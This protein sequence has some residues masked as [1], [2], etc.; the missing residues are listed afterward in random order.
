MSA[1]GEADRARDPR[2]ET[3]E[4]E[5]ARLAATLRSLE[6]QRDLQARDLERVRGEAERQADVI[7][8]QDEQIRYLNEFFLAEIRRVGGIYEGTLSWRITRPLRTARRA[9]FLATKL[10]WTVA[11]MRRAQ[12]L[13]PL[14]QKGLGIM[15][16]EGL[17]GI[18][19]WFSTT[20]ETQ[21]T[22]TLPLGAD[23]RACLIVAPRRVAGIARMMV[24]VL[25]SE[26]FHAEIAENAGDAARFGHCFVLCPQAFRS[27]PNRCIAV[28][29]DQ[30]EGAAWFTP[31]YLAR[32]GRARAVLDTS[33]RNIELL[34]ERGV[35]LWKLHHL[36]LDLERGSPG[37]EI[38]P[39]RRR[40][41]LVHG[42]AGGARLPAMLD[43]LSARFPG[44]E[45]IRNLSGEPLRQKLRSAAVVVNI[46]DREGALIET[47]RIFEALSHGALVVS[48]EGSD[49]EEHGDL[50]GLVDFV[51]PGDLE[52]LAAA[53]SRALE[54]ED[55]RRDRAEALRRRAAQD[56]NRFETWFRRVLLSLRMIGF[57]TFLEKA[58]GYPVAVPPDPRLCLSLPE[59][60]HRRMLFQKGGDKGFVVWDGL[61][62]R[63]AWAGAA[64][65]YK[66]MFR[67]LRDAG[68]TRATV[69][70]DDVLFPPDFDERL[71]VVERYL[72]QRPWDVFSGFIADASRNLRIKAVEE[73]E[74]TTFVS[75]DRTVSMVF[76]IYGAEVMDHLAQWDPSNAS[77][78]EN[79]IDRWLERRGGTTVVLTLPFLVRH[80]PDV[81]STI[82][83]FEN[84]HYDRV[85]QRSE[86]LLAER[87]A[88][89]RAGRGT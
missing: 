56:V 3:V 70:E 41:V 10:A 66:H 49:Q 61:K 17:G 80:R 71:R 7:R 86:R 5:V 35:E 33:L 74:G 68:V 44:I 52:A 21:G 85:Q 84:T 64:L 22:P 69:C 25:R 83:G 73:F 28:Q 34:G 62:A 48:E 29:V 23:P 53:L 30:L 31:A 8:A 88:A 42:G 32:L 77:V 26:G 89:F 27:L 24:A 46:H 9:S 81:S 59:T 37:P 79:T 82:W 55:H 18:R 78:H 72:S 4:E 39:L 2:R 50:D 87:V 36:P 43:R 20:M 54:D 12:G 13:A 76:N 65:S 57:E 40:G 47:A 11:R 75:I 15:T 51:P 6:A 60:R 38:D 14:V 16:R 67:R 58:P 1:P 63:P 19:L 45:V